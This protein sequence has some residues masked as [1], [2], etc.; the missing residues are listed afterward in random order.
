MQTYINQ[1]ID[2]IK[3]ATWK[4]EEPSDIWDS[5]DMTNPGEIEDISYVENHFYGKKKKLSEITGI[6]TVKL[7]SVSKLNQEQAAALAIELEK[8]LIHF[9]FYPDFPDFYPAHLK[10]VFFCRI[11]EDEYVPLSFGESHIEFCNYDEDTCP[12]PDYCTTCAEFNKEVEEGSKDDFIFDL[13]DLLPK[14]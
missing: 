3:L 2:D 4:I 6:D 9:N 7:P 13:D 12:F 8:L 11:W 5:V 10:Y 14:V 1:L